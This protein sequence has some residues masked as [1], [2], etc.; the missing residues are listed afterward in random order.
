MKKTITSSIFSLSLIGLIDHTASASQS[1]QVA[2]EE[3]QLSTLAEKYASTTI[4]HYKVEWSSG[5]Y[6]TCR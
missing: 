5:K 6:D 1:H 3:T 4:R 2:E